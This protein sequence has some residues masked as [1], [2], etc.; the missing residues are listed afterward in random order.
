MIQH[1]I[2]STHKTI[3]DLTYTKSETDYTCDHSKCTNYVFPHLDKCSTS[4]SKE[5]VMNK[6]DTLVAY[7]N[8]PPTERISGWIQFLQLKLFSTFIH[9]QTK[10]Q[11]ITYYSG[12]AVPLISPLLGAFCSTSAVVIHLTY[13]QYENITALPPDSTPHKTLMLRLVGK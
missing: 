6:T 8:V 3:L 10:W 5:K 2:R 11:M 12:T 9:R 7:C 13:S 1:F 4:E